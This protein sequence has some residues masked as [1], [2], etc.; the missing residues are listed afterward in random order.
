MKEVRIVTMTIITGII[1]CAV[2]LHTYMQ[3]LKLESY[4]QATKLKVGVIISGTLRCFDMTSIQIMFPPD[5]H[6]YILVA[7][8]NSFDGADKAIADGVV[9][10]TQEFEVPDSWEFVD[11]NKKFN[12]L[13]TVS[14]FY[15]NKLAY[16]E[17]IRIAPDV[18]IIVKYRS[19]IVSSNVLHLP[20][21]LDPSRLTVF[22]PLKNTFSCCPMCRK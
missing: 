14:M 5:Q 13:N 15:H 16:E 21:F 19:D 11:R 17:L 2:V 6:E 22:H 9:V 7:S 8:V 20:D 1:I 12:S 4:Y 10:I 18:D 3:N